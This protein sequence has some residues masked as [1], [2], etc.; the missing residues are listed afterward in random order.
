M[1]RPSSCQTPVEALTYSS[2]LTFIPGSAPPPHST[3]SGGLKWASYHFTYLAQFI[4]HSSMTLHRA[5]GHKYDEARWARDKRKDA[6]QE[7]PCSSQACVTLTN[8]DILLLELLLL[9]L[10]P[11]FLS[12]N[13]RCSHFHS[14][15]T[16]VLGFLTLQ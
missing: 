4:H 9:K 10:H 14:A 3:E 5:W 13:L 6:D 16:F 12:H 15:R 11:A 1:M 8:C 2:R 7:L